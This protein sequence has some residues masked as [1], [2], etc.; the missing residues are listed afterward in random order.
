MWR[1]LAWIAVAGALAARAATVRAHVAPSL[2]DN[3][4]YVKLTPLADRVR[5]AYTVYFGE[6]PGAAARRE[7]DA[8]HDGAISDAEA[9]AFGRRLA[10]QVGPRLAVTVDG[11]AQPVAWDQVDVGMGTA[12]TAGGSFSVDLVAWLCLPHA[13]GHHRIVLRD[14]FDLPRAGENE[15]RVEDELGVR[16]DVAR[17]GVLPAVNGLVRWRGAGGPIADA[18]FVLAFQADVTTRLDDGRCR[19]TRAAPSTGHKLW[20]ELGLAAILVVAAVAWWARARRRRRRR[21]SGR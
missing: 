4:R 21:A 16:V 15:L 18:G 11:V 19:A 14:R 3:N 7:I 1:R 10:D 2:D 6:V 9:S 8:D 5:L 20:L 12:T 13:G 17:L